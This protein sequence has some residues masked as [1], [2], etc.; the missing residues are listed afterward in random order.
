MESPKSET[1]IVIDA[2]EDQQ[3]PEPKLRGALDEV[4]WKIT[5]AEFNDKYRVKGSKQE[6]AEIMIHYAMGY[7][8]GMKIDCM[9]RT[10][11]GMIESSQQYTEL[12]VSTKV[13]AEPQQT[14]YDEFLSDFGDI[15]TEIP[16]I[17]Q[18][19]AAVFQVAGVHIRSK[20]LRTKQ[21]QKYLVQWAGKNYEIEEWNELLDSWEKKY[22]LQSAKSTK[23]KVGDDVLIAANQ[24]RESTDKF[25][26]D[27]WN[28]LRPVW[29]ARAGVVTRSQS[30]KHSIPEWFRAKFKLDIWGNVVTMTVSFWILCHRQFHV[31]N[32]SYFSL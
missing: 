4:D 16:R 1:V 23:R 31:T 28:L 6:L 24:E 19:N 17:I 27:C 5:K 32:S 22:S 26:I 29:P 3:Q 13:A 20:H 9:R 11:W 25:R 18:T 30:N 14:I 2:D 8:K 10:V 7:E 15:A 12:F 21:A